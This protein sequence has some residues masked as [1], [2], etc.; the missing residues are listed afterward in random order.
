MS[1][2]KAQNYNSK[3]KVRVSGRLVT[4]LCLF[5]AGLGLGALVIGQSFLTA[6]NRPPAAPRVIAP[7]GPS[8]E[9][10]EEAGE[11]LEA[12]VFR[13]PLITL[14]SPTA[15]YR[16]DTPYAPEVLSTDPMRGDRDAPIT[17]VHF[18][19][20]ASAESM[21]AAGA[22]NGIV[23]KYK[24]E[25][26]LVWK[27]FPSPF[28]E[29]AREA[30]VAARCA[31]QQGKFWEMHDSLFLIPDSELNRERLLQTAEALGL[32]RG[33]FNVCLTS[34]E[35]VN[36]VNRGMEEGQALDVDAIPVVFVGPYRLTGEIVQEEVERLVQLVSGP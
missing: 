2:L 26:R 32:E 7:D 23:E 29:G 1:K 20:F 3:L 27:D 30:A 33:A 9:T 15:A 6:M 24:N 35:Q 21:A 13:D 4:I 16:D 28:H 17:I 31:G 5:L 19:D 14:V 10:A 25:V 11:A 12:G 18:G 22:L 8:A 34:R 36:L